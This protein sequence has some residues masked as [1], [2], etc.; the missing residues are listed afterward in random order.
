[1]TSPILYC[2]FLIAACALLDQLGVEPP[3]LPP[4][5]PDKEAKL[6]WED[7]VRA[8]IKKLQTEN[9]AKNVAEESQE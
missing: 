3:D 8:A 5:D 6:P 1:M 2:S 9:E 7:E 4:Y